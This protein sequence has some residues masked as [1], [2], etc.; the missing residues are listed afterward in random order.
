VAYFVRLVDAFICHAGHAAARAARV[1][2]EN[3]PREP[4][5]CRAKPVE[6]VV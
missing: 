1:Q 3:T 2:I 4:R 6:R 5:V